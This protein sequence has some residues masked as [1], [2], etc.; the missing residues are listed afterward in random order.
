MK[1]IIVKEKL[2]HNTCTLE[3]LQEHFFLPA[4]RLQKCFEALMPK[5]RSAD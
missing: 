5:V 2:R 4:S 1:E 3:A